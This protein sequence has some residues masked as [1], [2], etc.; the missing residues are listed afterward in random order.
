MPSPIGHCREQVTVLL[1][2]AITNLRELFGILPS[3]WGS[4]KQRLECCCG[5][6]LLPLMMSQPIRGQWAWLIVLASSV[7][8]SPVRSQWCGSL[9][10]STGTLYWRILST[11]WNIY[12]FFIFSDLW[13]TWIASLNYP[14]IVHIATRLLLEYKGFFVFYIRLLLA[15]RA[16]PQ[17]LAGR[18]FSW[19]PAW[20]NTWH[21]RHSVSMGLGNWQ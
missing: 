15:I 8:G 12:R 3:P 2:N 17:V 14:E 13:Y 11:T 6:S 21:W 16:F 18:A 19:I 10:T 1:P 20:E 5:R 4:C 9:V 7:T